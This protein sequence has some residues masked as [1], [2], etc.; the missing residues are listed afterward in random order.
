MFRVAIYAR[1]SDERQNPTSAQDQIALCEEHA[2]RQDWKVINRLTDEAISGT[3]RSRP[4]YQALRTLIQSEAIDIVMAEALDRISR[5]QEETANLSKLCAFHNV[6]MFTLS[7]GDITELHVGMSSTINAIYLKQL[8]EKTHRGLEAR[9][10][11]GKS[12]G[13]RSYGYRIPVMNGVKATGDLEIVEEEAATVRQIFTD[14]A[15]GLG[16]KK[17]AARLNMEGIPSPSGKLWKA[18][19]LLGNRQR[20]TGILNNEIYIGKRIWNRLRYVKSVDGNRRVSRLNPPEEWQTEAAP[21]LQ[22]VSDELWAKVKARQGQIDQTRS[23]RDTGDRHH[24]SGAHAARRPAY[25]LSGLLHCGKCGGRM[26][27]GGSRPKRYYCA[28]A[29]EKGPAACEGMPGIAQT[30]LEEM[31]LGGIRD[32]LMQPEAVAAFIEA[33]E[34]KQRELYSQKQI[35]E[36]RTEKALK[37]TERQIGNIVAAIREGIF[38]ASTKSELEALEEKKSALTQELAGQREPIPV[39]PKNIAKIYKGK[40]KNLVSTLNDPSTRSQAID[41][42]RT[43]LDRIVIHHAGDKDTHEIELVGE[44]AALLALGTNENA[45]AYKA[46]AHSLKLVAG[47]H[48]GFIHPLTDRTSWSHRPSDKDH[49]FPSRVKVE[50]DRRKWIW[51]PSG[52]KHV[53]KCMRCEKKSRSY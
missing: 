27:I 1:F 18:N 20:G 40:V 51:R 10:K 6:K 47:A 26:N 46:T 16:P 34:R 9:V 44:L 21:Q 14:Y 5:D 31:V 11:S 45:A 38:T 7:E 17:I 4:G 22:I 48:L 33:Y 25:L 39:I 28:N 23:A 19:T 3:V 2:N 53:L 50:R 37:S 8:A 49:D 24:L 12:A 32:E 35:A 41:T 13:G 52:D 29:R 43:L 15:N 36:R 30:K 42:V